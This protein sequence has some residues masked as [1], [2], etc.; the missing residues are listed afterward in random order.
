MQYNLF[1]RIL[2][3]AGEEQD[4]VYYLMDMAAVRAYIVDAV[5]DQA[6]W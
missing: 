3:G 4:G 5:S 2:I 6:F 1:S